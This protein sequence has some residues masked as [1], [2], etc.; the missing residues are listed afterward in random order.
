MS[1]ETTARKSVIRRL[2]EGLKA[3][4][5]CFLHIRRKFNRSL[6]GYY[7][8][9][10]LSFFVAVAC[11]VIVGISLFVP[12]YIGVAD[13]G[14][15]SSVMQ[16][17]GLSYSAEDAGQQTGAYFV[18]LYSWHGGTAVVSTHG[19]LVNAACLIDWKLT[20][21]STFDIRFL[22]AI[23]AALYL[24]AVWIFARQA[25]LR[26][27]HA[28]EG[29]AI[30]LAVTVVF[31]D[32]SYL[33]YF[34]SLYPDPLVFI[35][36][37]Y[38]T[39][40]FMIAQRS[41]R[42]RVARMALVGLVGATLIMIEKSE[43]VLGTILALYCLFQ[44]TVSGPDVSL[45]L[46]AVM[47]AA[48]L[49]VTGFLSLSFAPTRFGIDS[50]LNSLTSGALLTS[51]DPAATL[52]A[53][54][55]DR[56]FEV[57]TD[58]SSYEA[59]PVTYADQIIL[60]QDLYTQYDAGTLAL[61]Y[62]RHPGSLISL[63]DIGTKGA[64]NLR[65]AECGNYEQS[66]GRP[67]YAKTPFFAIASTFKAKSAPQ[68]LGYVILLLFVHLIVTTRRR[69]KDL[70]PRA[71]AME[72]YAILTICLMG[73]AHTVYIVS[74]GGASE[75]SRYGMLYGTCIDSMTL[76]VLTEILHKLNVL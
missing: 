37:L 31:S 21:D 62:L 44:L 6:D 56:R 33:A 72:R 47:T 14:S 67:A 24:P 16:S 29:A 48:I 58:S 55:I 74:L 34:N 36:L 42:R 65:R 5:D 53:L 57:L 20:G 35:L 22:S 76:I 39:S 75:L 32:I 9:H 68:T 23:Y 70:A 19:W 30:A 52:D 46:M 12:P 54:G 41:P 43:W 38:L 18:R 26:A 15:L 25:L 1:G 50:K 17:A 66:V 7:S 69:A 71:R 60:Y 40:L 10:A 73:L 3:V 2:M 49:L 13:D 59:Y 11:G 8:P 45:R 27:K 51:I 63:L 4:A 64:F 61:Y 28:S